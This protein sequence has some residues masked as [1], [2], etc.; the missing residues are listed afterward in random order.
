MRITILGS[1]NV[2]GTL[3]RRW[4]QIG[5]EV[6]FGVRD[7]ESE[8]ARALVA[9]G[10]GKVSVVPIRDAAASSRV[11]VLAVP[12]PAARRALEAAGDLTGRI[13]VDCTNPVKEGL[14]GLSLGPVESAAEQIAQWCPGALV[15]KGFS[16]TGAGNMANPQYG[17]DRAG[18]FVCGDDERAKAVVSKLASELGLE[19]V[20]TGSLSTARYLEPLAM[21]WIHLAYNRGMGTDIAFKL[22]KRARQEGQGTV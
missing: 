12:W 16:T 17:R 6:I 4:A 15:V 20:D 9:E 18:M 5:H 21:L 8:K 10:L 7:P 14:A 13:L 2:G 11:V 22:L 19:V 3:G 1:G